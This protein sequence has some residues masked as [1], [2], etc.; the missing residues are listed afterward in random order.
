MNIMMSLRVLI[1]YI[2]DNMIG[3]PPKTRPKAGLTDIKLISA[4]IIEGAAS[5]VEVIWI[6]K[7]H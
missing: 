1:Y 3:V 7:S 6:R 5:G 2:K 4:N